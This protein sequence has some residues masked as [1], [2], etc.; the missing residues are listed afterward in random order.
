MNCVAS[1]V[2]LSFSCA[3]SASSLEPPMVPSIG[4][5]S[6]EAMPAQLTGNTSTIETG[7]ASTAI[8]MEQSDVVL[9][10]TLPYGSN[11]T[12]LLTPSGCDLQRGATLPT[13]IADA[14]NSKHGS[15]ALTLFDDVGQPTLSEK[16]AP[17]VAERLTPW[18]LSTA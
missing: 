5:Q 1:A 12:R 3:A 16:Y 4:E 15:L 9:I 17:E 8:A 18:R 10:A 2:V 6:L 11:G 14:T 13:I 7:Y